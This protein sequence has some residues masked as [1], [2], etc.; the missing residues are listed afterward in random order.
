MVASN[1]SPPHLP[2]AERSRE[3]ENL[4]EGLS[5]HPVQGRQIFRAFSDI[6]V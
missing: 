1:D 3:V 2:D 6:D 4:Q 5:V